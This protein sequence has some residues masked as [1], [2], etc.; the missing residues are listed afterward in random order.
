MKQLVKTKIRGHLK[1]TDDNGKILFDDHNDIV[2]NAE[3]LL[4]RCV[5]GLNDLDTVEAFN[6]SP[7]S[8]A[9]TTRIVYTLVSTNQIDLSFKF[10]PTDFNDTVDKLELGNSTEG[11]FSEV[12]GLSIL[13]DSS[14]SLNITWSLTF[15]I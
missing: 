4:R 12:T 8:L 2:T 6:S 13:K 5:V 1:V 9:T 15:N 3:N 11:V 14:T 10:L 7:T